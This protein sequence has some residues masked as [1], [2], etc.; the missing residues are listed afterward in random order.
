[1][2]IIYGS[3]HFIM[4]CLG[5]NQK[6]EAFELMDLKVFYKKEIFHVIYIFLKKF[7]LIKRRWVHRSKKNMISER[8]IFIL[9]KNINNFSALKKISYY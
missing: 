4:F 9:K 2:C 5:N 6:S 3:Y 8:F 7:K 1:M